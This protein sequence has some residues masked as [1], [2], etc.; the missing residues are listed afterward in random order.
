MGL[1]EAV[2]VERIFEEYAEDTKC[3]YEYLPASYSSLPFNRVLELSPGQPKLK[4]NNI[5]GEATQEWNVMD[6]EKKAEVT[7]PLIEELV[8]VRKE[9]D[10]KLRITPVHILNDV[11]ATVAKIKHE[12]HPISL[13]NVFSTDIDFS[14]TA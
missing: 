10:T 2:R 7:N 12:V 6:A 3:R 11:S 13:T 5:A 14:P 4:S 9:A 1:S 8:L